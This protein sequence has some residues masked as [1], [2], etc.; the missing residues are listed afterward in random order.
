MRGLYCTHSTASV[1]YTSSFLLMV[2]EK[3]KGREVV[4]WLLVLSVFVSVWDILLIG[5]VFGCVR[6]S[7]V[8]YG[9]VWYYIVCLVFYRIAG[10]PGPGL[11]SL[12]LRLCRLRKIP[13]LFCVDVGG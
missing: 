3:G 9:M 8:W 11:G 4:C 13:M 6:A 1:S 5:W 12:L 2:A 10:G 7:I